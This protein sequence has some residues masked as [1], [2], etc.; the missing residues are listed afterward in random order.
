MERA[1]VVIVGGGPAGLAAAWAIHRLPRA[2]FHIIL[3]DRLNDE[4]YI[5]YHRMCGEGISQKGLDSLGKGFECP[6]RNSIH[7][8][9][10]HWPGKVTTEAKVDGHIIDRP[11]MLKRL[12]DRLGSS[13]V[14]FNQE[15]VERI[16]RMNGGFIIK[17]RSGNE[18][19]ARHLVGADGARSI[20]RRDLFD[21]FQPIL[22]SAEQYLVEKEPLDKTLQFFFDERYIGKYRWEFPNGERAKIGFPTGTDQPPPN[23]LERH[24]RPIP[25]G[26]I[27]QLVS[28]NAC[29]IGD[30]AS[31]ANPITFGGLANS[32]IA[33]GILA[34]ALENGDLEQYQQGWLSHPR[35]DPL[36]FQAF[37]LLRSMDNGQISHVMAPLRFGPSPNLI[38]QGL[39]SD[40]RFRI[41]YRSQMLKAELGW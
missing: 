40:E 21:N 10:E 31:Q 29:L 11:G 8:V 41:I 3:L 38:M 4:G 37:Q 30:A 24:A 15:E 22:M 27:P 16:D 34:N 6:I 5:R 28:G 19:H 35:S 39:M 12:R 33:A 9:R 20:V 1:D 13:S 26:P 14:E 2:N 7:S 17:C 23:V 36:F 32:F 18:F 25:I